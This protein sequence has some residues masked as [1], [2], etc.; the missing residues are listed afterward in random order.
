MFVIATDIRG[1]REE[2]VAGETGLLVPPK[3]PQALAG[4][5]LSLAGDSERREGMGGAARARVVPKYGLENMVSQIESPSPSVSGRASG[6]LSSFV[7]IPG[8][9]R[10]SSSSS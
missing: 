5:V 3:D 4:A 9:I 2:V 1:C 6:M 7:S 10:S 8:L